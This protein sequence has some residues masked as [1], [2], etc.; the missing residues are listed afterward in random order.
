VAR[1]LHL[2]INSREAMS[3]QISNEA[4]EETA[5]T[6]S[7]D[8]TLNMSLQ[9]ETFKQNE[10]TDQGID[11]SVVSSQGSSDDVAGNNSMEQ[12]YRS[13]AYGVL[14]ALLRS[15]PSQEVIDHVSAFA[16]IAVDEDE[17][18]LSMSMLGLTANSS[19]SEAIN[20]EY[21]ELFI[22]LGRGELVPYGSWYLTGFLMEKPLGVLRDDLKILGIERDESVSEPEDHVAALCEVMSLLISDPSEG[23]DLETQSIFFEKHIAPWM[24]RF[25]TDLSESNSATFYKAVGR[26][27]AAFIKLENKYLTMPV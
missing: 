25:F 14:S 26:F 1:R 6:S 24:G 8:T 3:K 12:Q 19:N 9:T 27:G 21:H 23:Q 10:I 20:D 17:M 4:L 11:M 2:L 13:A 7:K 22:G 16:E 15:V 18:L 5:N